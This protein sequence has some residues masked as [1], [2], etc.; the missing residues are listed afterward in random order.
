MGGMSLVCIVRAFESKN[1]CAWIH[2]AG[3]STSETSFGRGS[4]FAQGIGASGKRLD[5]M[6]STGSTLLIRTGY[7]SLA[8]RDR[9][10][11]LSKVLPMLSSISICCGSCKRSIPYRPCSL[12]SPTCLPVSP[13]GI[14]GET[15]IS[16]LISSCSQ[17]LVLF[18]C[19]TTFG[20]Q[21]MSNRMTPTVH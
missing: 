1:S 11:L 19:S 21:A 20:R 8:R 10:C 16:P 15:M 12:E 5:L 9:R 18:R 4:H 14:A 6:D 7:D 3:I 17:S 13:T 2:Y